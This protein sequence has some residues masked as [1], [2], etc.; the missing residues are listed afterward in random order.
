MFH[1]MDRVR[2]NEL[3]GAFADE[4]GTVIR[5]PD[6]PA[7]DMILVRMDRDEMPVWFHQGDLNEVPIPK[8]TWLDEVMARTPT[9]TVVIYTAQGLPVEVQKHA[10]A[11]DET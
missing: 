6:D 10:V 9:E 4:K 3:Q 5:V 1:M 7:T 11:T 8:S 2:A